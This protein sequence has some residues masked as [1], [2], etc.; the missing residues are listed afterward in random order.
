MTATLTPTITSDADT[1]AESSAT[2]DEL[3]ERTGTHPRYAASG[4]SSRP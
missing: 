2:P 1:F 4:S 3:A